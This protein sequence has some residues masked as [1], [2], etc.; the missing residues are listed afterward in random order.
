MGTIRQIMA[1]LNADGSLKLEIDGHT[2]SD[3]DA[4]KNLALSS[5][6]AAAVR[7]VLVDQGID[8]SRLIAKGFG[9]GKPIDSNSTAEGKANNR[10]VE[11][12]KV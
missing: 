9:A 3:G 11:L 8:G 6:R 4:A 1:A 5:A 7:K 2:D 10:R 12:V